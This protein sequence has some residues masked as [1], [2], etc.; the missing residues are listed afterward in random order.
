MSD[1]INCLNNSVLEQFLGAKGVEDLRTKIIDVIVEEVRDQIK[2]SHNYI[3]SPED[4]AGDIYTITIE[5][6]Y[7]EIELLYKERIN[8]AVEKKLLSLG[9]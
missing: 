6:V 3:I 8:E 5:K 7:T 2:N 1:G 9:L 4:I